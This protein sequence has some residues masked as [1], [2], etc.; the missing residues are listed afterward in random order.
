M[1]WLGLLKSFGLD[2]IPAFVTK[3][4]VVSLY[5]SLHSFSILVYLSEVS[6]PS[7]NKMLL[8]LFSKKGNS[9]SENNYSPISVLSTLSKIF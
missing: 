9:V 3:V 2:D 1:K 4:V 5:L 6:L 8:F 7:A